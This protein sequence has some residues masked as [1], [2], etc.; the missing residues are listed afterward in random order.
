MVRFLALLICF[1]LFVAL[2]F[3]GAAQAHDILISIESPLPPPAWA[4]LERELLKANTEAC[5]EFFQ[6]YFDERGFLLC[7]ERWGG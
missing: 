5:S 3:I 4:L 6:K 2:P 7:V 1:K